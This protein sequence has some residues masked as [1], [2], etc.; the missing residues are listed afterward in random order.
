VVVADSDFVSDRY[1][2][3]LRSFP[4]YAGGPELFLNAVGWALEDDA[5]T[6]LRARVLRARPLDVDGHSTAA[7]TLVQWGNVAGVPIVV[8]AAGL[9]RW[10]WRT[11]ARRRQRLPD[12]GGGA[13]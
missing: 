3:L 8:C 9:L 7:A 13:T 12:T 11:R 4:I 10:R 5:L 2:E 1:M 6:A